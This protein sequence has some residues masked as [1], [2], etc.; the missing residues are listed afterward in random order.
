MICILFF[1]FSPAKVVKIACLRPRRAKL[2]ERGGSCGAEKHSCIRPNLR[3]F[4]QVTE[5]QMFNL[6]SK[7]VHKLLFIRCL[8][9]SKIQG[10]YFK[11]SA[12]Y[13]K[14]YGLYFLR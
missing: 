11:I 2:L 14:I 12:L 3:I 4:L 13:F 7:D 6:V 5:N 1:L 9:C 8:E 10:T